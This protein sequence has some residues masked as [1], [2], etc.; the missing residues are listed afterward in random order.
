[1]LA[2]GTVVAGYRI[3]RVLGAGGMGVVYEATQLSLDRT[4][5]LKVLAAELGEDATFVK[6]FRREGRLQAALDHPHI[7]TVHEAGET[8]HGLFIAMRLVRGATLKD[9][10]LAR[11]LDAGRALRLL[12]PVADALDAAHEA[13]L[14]HRDVKPQNILV[15][16]RDHPYLADFGLTQPAGGTHITATGQ[17]VGTFDYIAPEQIRGEAPTPSVDVYSLAG[18]LYECLTGQVPFPGRSQAAVIYA[19]MATEPPRPT[20]HRPEL[21]AALDAVLARGLAK[22]PAARPPTASALIEAAEHAFDRRSRAVLRPPG[23]VESPEEVGVR[24]PEAQVSTAEAPVPGR[25]DGDTPPTSAMPLPEALR[26]TRPAARPS[27]RGWIGVAAAVLIAALAGTLLAAGGDDDTPEE[28]AAPNSASVG[29]IELSYGS[30]LARVDSGPRIPGIP[31]GALRLG[32]G[33]SGVAAAL[34]DATGPTLLP[35]ALRSAVEGDLPKPA[36]VRAG[37]VS[38]YRYGPLRVRGVAQPVTIFAAPTSDGVATIACH[39]PATFGPRCGAVAQSLELHGPNALP[40]GPSPEYASVLTRIV[41]SLAAKRAE[42][43]ERLAR[44][45]T[46]EAQAGAASALALAYRDARRSLGGLEASPAIARPHAGIGSALAA[47][48]TAYDR[49]AAAARAGARRRYRRAAIA[50]KRG[51]GRLTAALKRLADAGYEVG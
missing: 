40:L 51:E 39:G 33:G 34:T 47:T 49:L 11:E 17:F 14:T 32:A 22:D 44:A 5:A 46:P 19:H 6:R 25:G 8:E 27:R 37:E 35:A 3:D 7:V 41:R 20:T 26:H 29:P 30:D 21:P 23:P 48:A 38:A 2:H 28:P 36:E 16:G 50:V 9:M 13:G 15:G 4:V 45:A 42:A 10:I 18:V 43:R 24:E 31:S 12:R 1:L